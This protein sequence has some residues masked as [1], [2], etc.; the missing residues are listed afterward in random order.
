MHGLWNEAFPDPQILGEYPAELAEII[1]PY[2]HTGDLARICR[3]IDWFGLNHYGPIYA[4]SDCSAPWGFAWGSEPSTAPIT[5]IGWP[6]YPEMFGDELL[7]VTRRYKLPIYVTEN[8]CGGQEDPHSA[9]D[10][11]DQR[12]IGY[13]RQYIGAMGEAMKGGADVRGYF[14]WSL[15]DNFEWGAGYANRF[16]LVSVDF[17]TGERRIKASG[18]WYAKLIRQARQETP[19]EAEFKSI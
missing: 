17:A 2:E 16:G 1:A 9:K 8:G 10:I 15:L 5:D 4:K 13:L 3:P 18:R 6:I 19:N 7:D 14:V 12:R 11:D